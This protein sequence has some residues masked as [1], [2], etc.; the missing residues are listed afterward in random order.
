MDGNSS[1]DFAAAPEK[2]AE[3]ELNFG[4]VTIGLGHAREDLGGMVETVVDEVVEPD[5]VVARQ[6]HRARSTHAAAEKPSGDAD[7]HERQGEQKWGQLE[8]SADDNSRKP[9]AQ[10]EP[11]RWLA[12]NSRAFC[13]GRVAREPKRASGRPR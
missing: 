10:P 4:C 3:R 7:E 8:H 5:V 9:R 6:T 2:A 1:V 12:C 13:P 11:A